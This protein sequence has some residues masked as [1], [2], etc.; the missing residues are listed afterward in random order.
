V[1]GNFIAGRS[2]HD[3]VDLAEQCTAW[4]QRVNTERP[5]D[6]TGQPPLTLLVEE[7]AKFSVLPLTAQDYGFFDCV[8]VSREGVV[9]IE[10]N[11]Y[12]VPAHLMGRAVTARIHTTRIEVFADH[13]LVATHVRSRE[14]YARIVNPAHFEAAFS[15][16]PRARVMVYRDWLCDLA[17]V[18]NSYVR[19]LCHK[20]RAEMKEQMIALYELAQEVGNADFVAALE[21][22]A[23]QQMYGAEYVRAIVSV[24]TASVPPSSAETNVMMLVPSLPAQ[25]EVERDL[26]QYERYVANLDQVLDAASVSTGGR[27]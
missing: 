6:A 5:S 14:Q 8:V 15:T 7:Q 11:R 26:A 22:A 27:A 4:L 9:A 18:V 20:R 17:P 24:P 1:K 10:T 21:L 2:F 13:E 23:E 19:A 12:S 25:H 3:D 16:K